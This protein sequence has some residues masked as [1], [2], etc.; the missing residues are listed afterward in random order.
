MKVKYDHKAWARRTLDHYE[1]DDFAAPQLEGYLLAARQIIAT[2]EAANRD[3]TDKEVRAFDEI[4]DKAWKLREKL[5]YTPP[6][7]FLRNEPLASEHRTFAEP[8]RRAP[9]GFSTP[10][11]AHRAGTWLKAILRR[12]SESIRQTADFY[13]ADATRAMEVG[14]P[15]AGGTL[16]PDDFERAVINLRES[17]GLA[18]QNC[19]VV[20]M[21]SDTLTIPRISGNTTVYFPGEGG[22]I[23]PSDLAT[24]A[25]NLSAK[26]LAVLTLMSSELVEDS[27]INLAELVSQNIGWGMAKKEDECLIDGDGSATYGNMIGLR[28]KM[29]DGSHTG[30]YVDA[31]AGHNLIS[32]IDTAD[33]LGLMQLLPEYAAAD[34]AFFCSNRCWVDA[35]LAVMLASGGVT[36]G[37]VAN[38]VRKAFYGAPIIT[39]PAMPAGA[40]DTDY[41][42]LIICFYGSMRQAVTFGDRRG[43]RVEVLRERYSD[44]D[45]VA[46]KATERIDIVAHDIVQVDDS[47]APGA[48]IGLRGNT[49]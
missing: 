8:A 25:V 1:K 45:Q 20:P 49:S 43:L 46:I 11:Q 32:E 24:D 39:S 48:L 38:G 35:F 13:G 42:D 47:T 22:S 31:T 7:D 2:S 34:A 6:P 27:A 40:S 30:S 37:E 36:A 17:Y 16:V 33:L 26:K 14:D 28:T 3:M 41:N 12:D 15:T 44:T 9:A 19:R 10:D 4:M 5:T 23:T 18:R 21:A 29:V